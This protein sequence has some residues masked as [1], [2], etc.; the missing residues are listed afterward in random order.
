VEEAQEV[1][2]NYT[3]AGIPLEV[4]ISDSQYMNKN[5]LFTLD[6]T[7]YAPDKMQVRFLSFASSVHSCASLRIR[8]IAG[9]REWGRAG[10][11]G[12]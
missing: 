5:R 8:T 10:E 2:D 1:V 6:P 7:N 12:G 4:F 11:R 9:V 3:R